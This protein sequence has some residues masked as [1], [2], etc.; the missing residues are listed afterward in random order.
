[1][2]REAGR[3]V[4]WGL[5][6]SVVVQREGEQQVLCLAGEIDLAVAE[7]FE[8]LDRSGAV[9]VD[10]IDAGAVT[11]LASAGVRLMLRIREQS[12]GQGRPAVLRQSSP[13]M[14]RILELTGLGA[15]FNGP[16]GG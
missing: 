6:G 4:T 13:S 15:I 5:P 14:D 7:E 3:Q 12:R 1:V 10:A 16:N 9:V 8:H 11:F 2:T